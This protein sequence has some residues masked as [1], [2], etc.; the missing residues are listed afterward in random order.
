M[1]YN[2]ILSVTLSGNK[3]EILIAFFKPNKDLIFK[4][5]NCRSLKVQ[6]H[7]LR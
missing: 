7:V 6:N 5:T 3:P 1:L 4:R 2:L